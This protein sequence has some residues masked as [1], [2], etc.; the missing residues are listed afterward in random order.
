MKAIHFYNLLKSEYL[1]K[2]LYVVITRENL[3]FHSLKEW[4]SLK[5]ILCLNF[6][7]YLKLIISKWTRII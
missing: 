4:V 3:Q 1:L 2:L 7:Y 5:S 6:P